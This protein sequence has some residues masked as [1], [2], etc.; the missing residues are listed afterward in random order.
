MNLSGRMVQAGSYPLWAA[1]TLSEAQSKLFALI[2][3]T[4]LPPL[5]N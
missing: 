3:L 2:K 4:P 1:N 5:L